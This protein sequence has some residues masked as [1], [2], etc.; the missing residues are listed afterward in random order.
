MIGTC[1]YVRLYPY[2]RCGL[3]LSYCIQVCVH[4]KANKIIESETLLGGEY[5]AH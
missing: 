2:M 3:Q 4:L 5:I 1:V